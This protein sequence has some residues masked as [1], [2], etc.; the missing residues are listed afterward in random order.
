MEIM[1]SGEVDKRLTANDIIDML[2][3]F[4]ENSVSKKDAEKKRT[5]KPLQ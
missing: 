1:L 4:Y 2:L 5:R 3:K